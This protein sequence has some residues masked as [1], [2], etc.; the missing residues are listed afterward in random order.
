MDK[1]EEDKA[2][3]KKDEKASLILY[4]EM[5]E[6]DSDNESENKKRRNEELGIVC[7]ICLQSYENKVY[8]TPCYHQ[9][10]FKCIIEWINYK[11]ECGIC[12]RATHKVIYNINAKKETVYFITIDILKLFSSGNIVIFSDASMAL[13]YFNDLKSKT[14]LDRTLIYIL[15]LNFPSSN[16]VLDKVDNIINSNSGINL[17][18]YYNNSK[19][20]DKHNINKYLYKFIKREIKSIY[21]INNQIL[22]KEMKLIIIGTIN[23][24]F[25]NKH[26]NKE[27]LIDKIAPYLFNN[28]TISLLFLK[29]ILYFLFNPF[30]IFNNYTINSLASF[31]SWV[32]Y[33]LNKE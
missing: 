17:T 16:N 30:F 4:Y 7:S 13:S 3:N 12:K 1:I 9:Y 2:E 31:D 21:L 25:N 24:I 19:A 33:T 23:L 29:Q 18:V 14:Y 28:R 11:V 8:L 6:D 26:K 27:H 10:C 20:N 15:N 5:D 22:N 32:K